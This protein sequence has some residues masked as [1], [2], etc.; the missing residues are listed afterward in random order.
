MHCIRLSTVVYG[1]LMGKLA[2]NHSEIGRGSYCFILMVP[3]W[4]L[5]LQWNRNQTNEAIFHSHSQF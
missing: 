4:R 1:F 3:E 2:T 5:N